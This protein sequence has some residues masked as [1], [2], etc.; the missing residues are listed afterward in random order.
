MDKWSLTNHI[1]SIHERNRPSNCEI[2]EKNFLYKSDLKN[3]IAKVHEEK[4]LKRSF[5]CE[6]CKKCFAQR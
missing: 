5:Q 2:C 1:K 3:H 6:L 4:N